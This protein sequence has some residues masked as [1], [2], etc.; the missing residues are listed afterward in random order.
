[1]R[2]TGGGYFQTYRTAGK[3]YDFS[4][5]SFIK[6]YPT[7]SLEFKIYTSMKVEVEYQSYQTKHC[8]FFENED[9]RGLQPIK[10]VLP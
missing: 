8:L 1:M 9:M 6:I 10:I 3:D 4:L 5:L 7:F 2:S